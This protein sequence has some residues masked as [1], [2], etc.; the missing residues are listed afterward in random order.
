M[1]S[2]PTEG[3]S[4]SK[5]VILD[6]KVLTINRSSKEHL[7]RKPL[8]LRVEENQNTHDEK[9]QQY[10]IDTFSASGIG[11][12]QFTFDNASI[13]ELAKHLLFHMSGSQKSLCQTICA[14]EKFFKW[15]DTQPEQIIS[16]LP[17]RKWVHKTCSIAAC[18]K[19]KNTIN[20]H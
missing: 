1:P 6:M 12:T 5:G 18:G 13:I 4:A 11:L 3:N 7:L 9:L 15:L 19:A 20:V 16:K 10:F 8:V 2:V 14:V 17:R